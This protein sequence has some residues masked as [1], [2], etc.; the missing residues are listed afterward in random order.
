MSQ[1]HN[2]CVPIF[3]YFEDV[4]ERYFFVVVCGEI[5]FAIF[6]A[7]VKT[8]KFKFIQIFILYIEYIDIIITLN[9]VNI[10]GDINLRKK[11]IYYIRRN[12]TRK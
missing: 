7:N 2:R 8:S 4:D 6:I 10:F 9:Y 3:V 11:I 1:H 5:F 12:M